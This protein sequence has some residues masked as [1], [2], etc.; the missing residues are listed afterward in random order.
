MSTPYQT[1]HF[2]FRSDHQPLNIQKTHLSFVFR[3]IHGE[4]ACMSKH[5]HITPQSVHTHTHTH[6]H[7]RA[8][9][10]QVHHIAR[11]PILSTIL[12]LNMKHI[13]HQ[14][15]TWCFSFHPHSLLLLLLD[16]TSN[17]FLSSTPPPAIR[18]ASIHA[19]CICITNQ[20]AILFRQEDSGHVFNFHARKRRVRKGSCMSYMQ[21]TQPPRTSLFLFFVLVLFYYSIRFFYFNTYECMHVFYKKME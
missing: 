3:K 13:I 9:A 19:L 14:C 12:S 11:F 2:F 10:P 18:P 16:T 5:T 8:R 17:P 15:F 20:P 7:T 6:T 1:I 21:N 4:Y